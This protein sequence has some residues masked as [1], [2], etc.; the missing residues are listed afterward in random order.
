MSTTIHPDRLAGEWDTT[1]ASTPGVLDLLIELEVR[2]DDWADDL[3]D[4]LE[5]EARRQVLRARCPADQRDIAACLRAGVGSG[6]GDK[7]EK[8]AIREI[9]AAVHS[10]GPRQREL[11]TVGDT[12]P[13]PRPPTRRGRPK[14]SRTRRR[15]TEGGEQ[16]DLL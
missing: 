6:R 15:A 7:T 12:P 14:G 9:R 5:L 11:I 16:G 4:A 2:Q 8:N 13:T 1:E 10:D 3:V